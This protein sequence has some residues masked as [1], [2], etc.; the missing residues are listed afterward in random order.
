MM[1][2][3]EA[4]VLAEAMVRAG[5]TA[6]ERAQ[7]AVERNREILHTE[8]QK[9][10]ELITPV[11]IVGLGKFFAKK[12][13]QPN[14][15]SVCMTFNVPE[16]KVFIDLVLIGQDGVEPTDYFTTEDIASLNEEFALLVDPKLA[17]LEI[18]LTFGGFLF[19]SEYLMQ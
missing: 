4:L 13:F 3:I 12:Y 1:K 14:L 2:N 5:Q 18:S 11:F 10:M 15:L 8:T 16:R 17:E 9:V 7:Q 6:L 19:P